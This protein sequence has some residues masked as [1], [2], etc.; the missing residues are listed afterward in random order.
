M[1]V[2]LG[3]RLRLRD[4]FID[5]PPPKR[6]ILL[7]DLGVW[8]S[9]VQRLAAFERK[10]A[11]RQVGCIGNLTQ[12]TA[13]AAQENTR[14]SPPATAP[15][16]RAT[17]HTACAV[18]TGWCR[19]HATARSTRASRGCCRTPSTYSS[20]TRACPWRRARA[21]ARAR[22]DG[23]WLH[24]HAIVGVAR[25]PDEAVR[26]GY[27][28][29]LWEVRRGLGGA[30]ACAVHPFLEARPLGRLPHQVGDAHVAPQ[31]NCARRCVAPGCE[32]GPGHVVAPAC[33]SRSGM[34][35]ARSSLT[36]AGSRLRWLAQRLPRLPRG[37]APRAAARPRCSPFSPSGQS[38]VARARAAR[39][40]RRA[41]RRAPGMT[42][43]TFWATRDARP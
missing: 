38:Q 32:G 10:I 41:V 19:W 27:E 30:A 33:G 2:N 40:L 39:R 5:C 17:S 7:R 11:E 6:R 9:C 15:P 18:S 22:E 24:R 42:I 23:R 26:Q 34:G 14:T 20:E 28:R 8:H 3:L 16:T 35:A 43:P 37:R 25:V 31:R 1:F 4:G 29:L 12:V 21:L 13:R 36:D